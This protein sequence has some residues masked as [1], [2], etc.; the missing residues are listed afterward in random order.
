[1]KVGSSTQEAEAVVITNHVCVFILR[2]E[3]DVFILDII[4]LFQCNI[5]RTQFT[6]DTCP[7]F[8]FCFIQNTAT[9]TYT[10]TS[11]TTF[12]AHPTMCWMCLQWLHYRRN[13]VKMTKALPRARSRERVR[14]RF[15][16]HHL[17]SQKRQHRC[18]RFHA[19]QVPP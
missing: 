3:K 13:Y 8:V 17:S 14:R 2:M 15:P 6:H 5:S 18:S 12:A 10:S 4:L 19:S 1:M 9:H 16:Y 7:K 11:C